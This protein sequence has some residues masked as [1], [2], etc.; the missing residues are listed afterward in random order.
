[1][2]DRIAAIVIILLAFGIRL[3]GILSQSLWRDEVD[4]VLFASAPLKEVLGYFTR[5]GWNGPL[6]YLLLKGWL[7]LAGKGEFALRYFS[8]LFGVLS[9]P[10]IFK[11]ARKFL[12]ERFALVAML[13]S[14]LSPYLVWYSQ[15]G[16]MYGLWLFLATLAF[17]LHF[18]ALERGGL[19][20]WILYLMAVTA[21]FYVHFH[22][23]FMILGQLTLY[24]WPEYRKRWR[25]GLLAHLILTLP[26]WP[27]A[28]W[29][30]PS[31][32]SPNPTGFPYYPLSDMLGILFTGWSCGI[33]STLWPWSLIPAGLTALGALA[34]RKIVLRLGAI[35]LLPVLGLF[36]ICLRK[37]VFTDRYLIF[38]TPFFYISLSLGLSF[39]RAKKKILEPGLLL[40]LFLV[41]VEALLSQ[42]RFPIKSDFRGAVALFK[43]YAFEGDT[44]VF[45]I[46]YVRRVFDYYLAGEKP[47]IP[48]EAP[49]TNWGMTPKQV[50]NYLK[51]HTGHYRRVWLVLSEAEMW[52]SRGL[53]EKWFEEN[54]TPELRG[55]L[56]RVTITLYSRP[57][58]LIDLRALRYRCFLPLVLRQN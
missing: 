31:F 20:R 25:E 44:V 37:P 45:Q 10:L 55:R 49:Y 33:L 28:R 22:S 38:L 7:H 36:G 35:L 21:N 42:S 54:F 57:E 16:K 53:V 32:L 3:G 4:A 46:P 58:P 41:D 1:M 34:E 6:Y 11:L 39:W 43:N 40:A 12:P 8:L 51:R 30:I 5:P 14:G 17:F 47:Y 26:F 48:V 9:L 2:R 19:K 15:E 24:L 18:K 13:L 52:D 27:A 23:L 50:D 56:A 29:L